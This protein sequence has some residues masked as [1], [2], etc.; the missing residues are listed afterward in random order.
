MK[1]AIDISPL[2]GRHSSDHRVRGTGFYV[3]DLKSSLQKYFSENKYHFFVNRKGLPSDIDVVHYPYFEPFFQ[4]LPFLKKYP[5]VITIHDLIP[6]VF[7]KHFP[8]GIKGNIRW[9]LQK[10]LLRQIDQIITDSESS[11]K[12][13][14]RLTG[15]N[16]ERITVIYLAASEEFTQVSEIKNS[17]MLKEVR[18]KY[19]LPEKY[20]LYVG[21][22]TWNKNLPRIIQ[23]V[24]AAN[25]SLVIVG[26]A[27]VDE[28]I[29][30]KNAW[31]ND[32]VETQRFVKNNKQ[33]TRLGFVSTQD[34]I[35]IYKLA[36]IFIMPSLYEGFG[37]P[38]LEAMVCGCP[39]I[40][41]KEGSLPEVAGN[42]AFYVDAYSSKS[43]KD[44]IQ[45]LYKDT[46]LRKELSDKGL[47]QAKK[48][49]WEK[50]VKETIRVYEKIVG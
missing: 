6:L 11:K 15:I 45:F 1:I 10:I 32:L 12:D 16:G 42:A 24:E 34:L 9:Q 5:S 7:P 4:T 44:G 26:K 19:N 13:I 39:V 49:S 31:N 18:R 36:T 30:W 33:I 40:T 21:D 43:I 28:D 8:S 38:V 2:E 47:N 29:N 23:A 17:F 22:G 20:V 14:I 3:R 46:R 41:T 35:C 50:T 27:L 48:F 25:V 37:L